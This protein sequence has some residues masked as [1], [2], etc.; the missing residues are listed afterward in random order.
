MSDTPGITV[1]CGSASEECEVSRVSGRAVAETLAQFFPVTL[2]DLPANFLPENLYPEETIIFPALHGTFGEDG[3]LQAMLEQRGFAYVGCDAKA[4]A[5]CM[6]KIDAKAVVAGSGFDFAQDLTFQSA[7]PPPAAE[8]IAM[9][10]E[11]VVVKPI[12]KGSSVGLHL[13]NGLEHL[14]RVLGELP[15]GGW[16]L[17]EFV[18][19]REMTVGLLEGKAMGIVEVIPEGGVYDYAHKYTA[20]ATTYRFPAELDEAVA[21]RVR[22]AAEKAFALCGCRDFARLDFIL[23]EDGRLCFLEINTIP[24]LT[25]TSLLP[26]SASCVGLDFSALA[27]RMVAPAIERYHQKY[28]L[29]HV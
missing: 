27:R 14:D 7:T 16:M 20:G 3:Q 18:F 17:E 26:K 1:L 10:G 9:L 21:A 19:G 5:L 24:G 6:N 29:P 11:R 4:S 12:D 25:P 23:L 2:V 28:P 8:M 15:P 22:T 13:V